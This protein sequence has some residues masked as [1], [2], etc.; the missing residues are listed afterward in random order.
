MAFVVSTRR[1]P[2]PTR[3]WCIGS[4]TCL[5]RL[6]LSISTLSKSFVHLYSHF[7]SHCCAMAFVV[8]TRRIPLP[9]RCW[10]IG[11]LI[12]LDLLGLS[13]STLS[14]SFVHLQSHLKSHCWAMSFVVSPRRIPPPTRYWCIGSLTCLVRLGL[15]I[16]TLSRSFVHLQS[17]RKSLLRFDG[18]FLFPSSQISPA[19][20]TTISNQVGNSYRFEL[21]I[22]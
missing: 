17:H 19:K 11:S 22:N 8:S 5:V 13:I 16:S 20:I 4:L 3:C 10:C 1:I 9:T 21:I 14:R 12:Y 6:G 2:L 7:K 15:S 18:L